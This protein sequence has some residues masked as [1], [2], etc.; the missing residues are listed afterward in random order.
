M[1]TFVSTPRSQGHFD[2]SAK[3]ARENNRTKRENKENNFDD[4]FFM[5]AGRVGF[6]LIDA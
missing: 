2:M 5:R 1:G 4:K 3:K 6:A